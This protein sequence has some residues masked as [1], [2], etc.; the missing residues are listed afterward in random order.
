MI[1]YSESEPE[2]LRFWTFAMRNQV[3]GVTSCDPLVIFR[4]P[5]I[6]VTKHIT[7]CPAV[8]GE[9][10]HHRAEAASSG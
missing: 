10:T 1:H 6:F 5:I 4:H 9:F 8:A 3:K 2:Q 7:T